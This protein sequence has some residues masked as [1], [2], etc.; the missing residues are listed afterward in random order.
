MV[1]RDESL[2]AASSS[3]F[4]EVCFLLAGKDMELIGAEQTQGVRQLIAKQP[5]L[6]NGGD[7]NQVATKVLPTG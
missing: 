3:G 5:C 7:G 6:W 2:A 1:G 4:E